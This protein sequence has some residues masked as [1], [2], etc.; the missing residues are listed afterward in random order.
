MCITEMG[1]AG[2][3]AEKRNP[4]EIVSNSKSAH[5]GDGRG[6]IVRRKKET[7]RILCQMPRVFIMACYS[8]HS[9]MPAVGNISPSVELS[10]S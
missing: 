10:W 2:E 7:L 8:I 3:C 5:K 9:L 4:K 1:G 6:G